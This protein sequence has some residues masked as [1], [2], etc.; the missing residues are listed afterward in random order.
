M[1]FSSSQIP[2]IPV[3]DIFYKLDFSIDTEWKETEPVHEKVQL[4]KALL[5]DPRNKEVVKLHLKSSK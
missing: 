1:T 3:S 5:T 4:T 2:S